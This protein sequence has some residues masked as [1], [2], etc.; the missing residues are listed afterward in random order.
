MLAAS[1][2]AEKLETPVAFQHVAQGRQDER[3]AFGDDNANALSGCLVCFL[4]LDVQGFPVVLDRF[5][6]IGRSGCFSSPHVTAIL[7]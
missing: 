4:R 7:P 3:I 1:H 6:G 2:G 5:V